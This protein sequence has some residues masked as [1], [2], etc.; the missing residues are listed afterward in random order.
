MVGVGE[1]QGKNQPPARRVLFVVPKDVR[2]YTKYE[3]YRTPEIFNWL[4]P[5][6]F[7]QISTTPIPNLSLNLPEIL[8]EPTSPATSEVISR[9][10]STCACSGA[11][12]T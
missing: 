8:F 3:L 12:R 6:L 9:V 7:P 2:E 11:S 10:C 1:T 4:S 5:L